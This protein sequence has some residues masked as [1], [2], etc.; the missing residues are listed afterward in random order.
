MKKYRSQETRNHFEPRDVRVSL[1]R[2]ADEKSEVRSSGNNVPT[3]A[4]LDAEVDEGRPV[5]LNAR[6]ESVQNLVKATGPKRL[7]GHHHKG[8]GEDHLKRLGVTT[9]ETPTGVQTPTGPHHTLLP[10]QL[11]KPSALH[12]CGI[13]TVR[14]G[15]GAEG[16]RERK[17]R[18]PPGNRAERAAKAAL[19]NPTGCR[20]PLGPYG[21]ELKQR[22]YLRRCSTVI[23]TERT[24]AHPSTT[25]ADIQWHT[26]EG[27]VRRLQERIDRATTNTAWRTVKN[28]QKLLV[29][30]TS[31][32]LL[33]IRRIPQEN[34]GKHPAGS[35]GMVSATPE[36][37]W[38]VFQEGLR[39]KGYKPRPV[40]RVYIP[41]DNGKQRPLGIPTGK[42]RVMP[43]LVKAALEPA[44]EARFAAHSY[45]CRPGRCTMDAVEAIHTPMHRQDGSPWVLDADIS[46]CCENS[47][48]EPLVAQLPVFTTTRRQW[49]TAGVVEGGFCSPTDTGTPQ[50]GVLSPL[51]ANV[52]LDGMERW[53]DAEYADR[54]PR[55]PSE[56]RGM[57]KGIAVS[58]SADDCVTT[59][60]TREVLATSARPRIEQFLQE[61]GLALNAAKTRRVPIKEG[62][63]FLG[64]HLR[65]FG[66][67]GTVLT[68]P[69]K[70]KVLK[71]V[72]ATRTSLDAQK[73]TPAGQVSKALH[74]VIRGWANYSR[75]CAAKHVCQKVRQAQWQM[76]WTW[77]K[78]RHPHKSRK[79]VKARSFRNDGYWTF[80]E[81]KAELVKPDATPITRFTKVTGRPSPYDPALRQ[82]WTERKKQQVRRETYAKQQLMLHQK[83]GY[84]CAL[85]HLPFIV[86][87]SRETDH[88]LPTSQG[89]TDEITNKRLVHPW[90]HRQHH[91]KDGRQ[92]PRA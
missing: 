15:D 74:P 71:H 55:Q 83:Q 35:D 39:L 84:R 17:K 88:I 37:R 14:K 10:E 8:R 45:G 92:R 63:N 81:G 31:N 69:Q 77:A 1:P 85:C 34:Q 2:R 16:M 29:R 6:E 82:Y 75:Y 89:G 23:F 12:V 9:S 58:R 47:D 79:W 51:L 70:E 22:P 33:A 21:R 28:L 43:A 38:R 41:K 52:A 68:V 91:Q 80:W 26:V 87:E 53:F 61:R 66:K 60:P 7:R 5:R 48:H 90:C 76:L 13:P 57:N 62:W 3:S 54:R 59:A 25:W 32:R 42:D 73:Q 50:G 67:Q 11:G 49:R 78:R 64:F 24:E 4:S 65:K 20:L 18:P 56:R 40:R 46:G 19:L 27:H 72:R 44:W 30:A 36:A 86:G